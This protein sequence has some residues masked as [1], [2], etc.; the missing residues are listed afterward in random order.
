MAGILVTGGAGFI[1][2][3]LA[4]ALVARGDQVTIL[5]NLSTGRLANLHG[6]R[7]RIRL[8]EGSFADRDVV[9]SALDGIDAV[10][11]QGALPSVPKS[12]S[13]PLETNEANVVG[14][15]VLLEASRQANVSRFVYA[16]SSSAYGD[17]DA[18]FKEESLEPRPKS[19]YAVQKLT[20][21]MYCRVYHNLFN[22][23]TIALRYFN[24]FGPR[25]NPASE[26]AADIPAFVTRMLEGL[27]PVIF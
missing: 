18:Q 5:D 11:H 9:E 20:G 15:L 27:P 6:I 7:D 19:P 16:A 1:G 14:T 13:L 23:P 8:V 17:H 25:Q 26:Y 4:H 3:N 22:L 24:V 21:E 12:L 10:L 2:S